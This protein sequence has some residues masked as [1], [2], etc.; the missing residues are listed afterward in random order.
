[1][2]S[3]NPEFN[4]AIVRVNIYRDHRQTIQYIRPQD[5]NKL[6]QAEL[7]VV[8]EAAAIPLTLVKNLLGPYL[9]FLSSTVNG[10][11]G[12]GRSLSLKLVQKLREQSRARVQDPQG[13]GGGRQLKEVQLEEPIRYGADDPVEKWLTELLCLNATQEVD[14]LKEGCPHPNECELYFVNRD[15]LFSYHQSSERFLK[16]IMAIFVSS[17]YKN[18]PND[19]LLLSDAP[20]H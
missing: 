12:T 13:F 6:S 10:Y 20:A 4:N 18:S 7:L 17:H 8:D 1:M 19:L 11:E 14:P 9:V 2:Q 16:K 5:H 3:T 15:T